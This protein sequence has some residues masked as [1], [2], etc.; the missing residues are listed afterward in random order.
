MTTAAYPMVEEDQATGRV[1]AVYAAA[2]EQAPFVP[3]LLKT[4]ALCPGYLVLAWNQA[5]PVLAGS[6][7]PDAVARLIATVQDAAT[8]PPEPTDRKLLGGFAE[9][10]GRMLL[11]ACGLATALDGGLAG[12]PPAAGDVPAAPRGPLERTL[13]T[14]GELPG[15]AAAFGRI[16][17]SL[18]TPLVNSIWRRTAAEGRL[19]DVWRHL[20]PQVAQTG[21]RADRLR[22]VAADEAARLPWASVADPGALQAAGIDD[23][24]PGMAAALD[25]YVV[26]LPRVLALVACCAPRGDDG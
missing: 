5:S 25:A 9:P 12:R 24:A 2:L 4:L 14:V 19:A 15:D 26:T 17:A 11:L 22:D 8:P 10:L 16:R 1:A 7:L 23:A 3:S 21:E 13:P 6:E 18:R 20:E